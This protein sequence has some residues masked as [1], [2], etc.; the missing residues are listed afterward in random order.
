MPF[1]GTD[2]DI[3]TQ[4]LIDA[5]QLLIDKGWC[6]K[7]L[8]VDR[9]G[10]DISHNSP[11]AVGFCALGAIFRAA[12][13]RRHITLENAP[14]ERLQIAMGGNIPVFNNRQTSVE[15]VLAAFDRA[16]AMGGINGIVSVA[17]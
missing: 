13:D 1:D 15:P 16:I 14:F 17:R 3:N 10:R 8:A 5:K 12:H 6:T 9:Y 7:C 11:Q 4:L 2:L